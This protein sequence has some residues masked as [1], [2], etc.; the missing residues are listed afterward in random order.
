MDSRKRLQNA[1]EDI[2]ATTFSSDDYLEVYAVSDA[3]LLLNDVPDE[4]DGK[5][6]T[7]MANLLAAAEALEDDPIVRVCALESCLFMQRMSE[8]SSL[9][10]VARNTVDPEDLI[11][12][13]EQ[14]SRRIKNEIPW[15][16]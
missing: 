2:L 11:Q 8:T 6:P 12:R 4:D 9:C 15:L 7:L 14:C 16:R 13:M 5:R 3:G 10:V 1:F